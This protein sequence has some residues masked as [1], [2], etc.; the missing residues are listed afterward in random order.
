[1]EDADVV[2]VGA[3]SRVFRLQRAMPELVQPQGAG[4]AGPWGVGQA[5]LHR[6]ARLAAVKGRNNL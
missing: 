3:G 2:I 4:G 5:M 1:M 6:P